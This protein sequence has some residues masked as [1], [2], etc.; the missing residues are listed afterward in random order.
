MRVLLVDDHELFRAGLGLLIRE[1]FP[2][3][4][5]LHANTLSHGVDLAMTEQPDI[6][7]LDLELPDGHDCDALVRLKDARSSLPVV[8]VSADESME[9]VGRCLELRA[10]GYVPKSSS[11]EALHAAIVAVLSGGVFLPAAS[12]AGLRRAIDIAGAPARE[13]AVAQPTNGG[14]ALN[15]S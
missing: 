9:T 1:L 8:V 5:L 11:P 12:I 13:S 4:E 2:D 14:A 3:V 7:F 15:S 6:V 10:M